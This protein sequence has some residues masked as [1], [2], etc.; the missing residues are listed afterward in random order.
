[1]GRGGGSVAGSGLAGRGGDHGG[2]GKLLSRRLLLLLLM[3]KLLWM[4]FRSF[5]GEHGELV[6][7]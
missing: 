1:M 3:L 4:I 7:T 6:V 5:S 2:T